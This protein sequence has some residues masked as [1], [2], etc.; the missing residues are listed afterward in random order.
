MKQAPKKPG[1]VFWPKTVLKK[2]LNLRANDSEFSA[3]EGSNDS[4]LEEDDRECGGCEANEWRR[5]RRFQAEA[6]GT[7]CG[8]FSASS[9]LHERRVHSFWSVGAPPLADPPT[10][11][12]K[13]PL[14]ATVKELNP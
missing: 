11:L 1:E 3:D 9:P 7:S 14:P 5:G 10:P 8:S 2:W 4:G 13:S 12:N 6:N